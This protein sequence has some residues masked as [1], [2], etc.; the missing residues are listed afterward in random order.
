MSVLHVIGI[1]QM[2]ERSVHRHLQA[3]VHRVRELV[4]HLAARHAH[5]CLCH[6]AILAVHSHVAVHHRAQHSVLQSLAAR[7]VP[8]LIVACARCHAS[9]SSH[10]KRCRLAHNIQL[11]CRAVK[12][13]ERH[14]TAYHRG[15][16]VSHN[17]IHHTQR[18]QH[19]RHGIRA[20]VQ[21]VKVVA[22]LRAR[23]RLQRFRHQRGVCGCSRSWDY[24]QAAVGR[25]LCVIECA[26]V[27][28][29]LSCAARTHTGQACAV[30]GAKLGIHQR[31]PDAVHVRMQTHVRA[32]R[33]C[34]G[35][36][37]L[38]LLDTVKA[39]H[40]SVG[41]SA[42][43]KHRSLEQSVRSAERALHSLVVDRVSLCAS[44]AAQL[45]VHRI[46]WHHAEH[47]HTLRRIAIP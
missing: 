43:V 29:L 6:N 8:H 7:N 11:A 42:A 30:Q 5:A 34:I 3:S 35:V 21:S 41:Q 27:N 10:V 28:A 26:R 15:L 46:S 23:C 1:A 9:S 32:C 14:R 17:S 25:N 45:C 39:R 47:R 18:L 44:V 2:L 36:L 33:Q 38:C 37:V 24:L 13:H 40:A 12:I 4:Y 31:N 19:F 16:L 22:R 20:L